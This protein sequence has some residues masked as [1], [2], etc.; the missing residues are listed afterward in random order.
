MDEGEEG[1]HGQRG[2]IRTELTFL[3]DEQVPHHHHLFLE[4]FDLWYL[5]FAVDCPRQN[6]V[7]VS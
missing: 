3:V 4:Y 7:Q 2:V 6:M 5:L 1:E